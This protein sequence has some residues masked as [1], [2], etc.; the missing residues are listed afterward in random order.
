M[1][2]VFRVLP[3]PEIFLAPVFDAQGNHQ[4]RGHRRGHGKALLKMSERYAKPSQTPEAS[5]EIM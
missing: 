1:K 3:S 2:K 5:I 4:Q